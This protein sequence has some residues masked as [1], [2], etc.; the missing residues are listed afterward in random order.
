ML[1]NIDIATFNEPINNFL[2]NNLT[3]QTCAT[4]A[5]LLAIDYATRLG[6]SGI[7]SEY[8][9]NCVLKLKNFLKSHVITDSSF[10]SALTLFA[11]AISSEDIN[12]HDRNNI[13]NQEASQDAAI[14][15]LITM[16]FGDSSSALQDQIKLVLKGL[17]ANSSVKEVLDYF[18]SEPQIIKNIVA[19]S[20][21]AGNKQKEINDYALSELDKVF[22]K[23]IALNAKSNSFKQQVA[24]ITT[25]LVT[26]A[27]ATFCTVVGGAALPV[28][29][30]PTAII[31]LK[32]APRVGE[33]IGETILNY[34]NNF[35]LDKKNFQAVKNK[36]LQTI[37]EA[38]G[39]FMQKTEDM[40]KDKML[41]D[42]PKHRTAE[43][44]AIKQ[45]LQ[46]HKTE[47]EASASRIAANKKTKV[48]KG[49][50]V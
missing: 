4:L 10:S 21:K 1:K 8:A 41:Q 29:I 20:L 19:N 11:V 39:V 47:I 34:D 12:F 18:S 15:A 32:L 45:N 3:K 38:P 31:A 30:L 13:L 37:I 50:L 35:K 46:S 40:T 44:S 27:M 23:N 5:S 16:H 42:I 33:K 2:I 9:N 14:D 6:S 24:S 7:A 17:L 43:L 28:L 49:R 22:H 36:I 48:I 25:G 26:L